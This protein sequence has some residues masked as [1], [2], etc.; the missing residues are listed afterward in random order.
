MASWKRLERWT[1]LYL[2]VKDPMSLPH[3]EKARAERINQPK[4]PTSL[5]LAW[6]FWSILPIAILYGVARMYLI[7]EAFLE[8]RN[9]DATAFVNVDWSVYIPHI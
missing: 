1:W 9:V 2:K 8:L 5:P 7:V 6:E 4:E 3:F